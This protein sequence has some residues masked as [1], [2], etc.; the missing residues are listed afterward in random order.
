M[1]CRLHTLRTE[2]RNV[3]TA[4]KIESIINK[5]V[6]DSAAVPSFPR[7]EISN[8][9]ASC[10]ERGRGRDAGRAHLEV[11]GGGGPKL[12]NVVPAA[13][14]VDQPTDRQLGA[15]IAA[16]DV[17]LRV[18]VVRHEHLAVGPDVDDA[19]L[20][21]GIVRLTIIQPQRLV[22]AG[23]CWSLE[24]LGRKTTWPIPYDSK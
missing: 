18:V 20:A 16:A 23:H 2:T 3:I 21:V 24:N 10:P 15:A 6:C 9:L 11:V 12:C 13:R 14:R 22:R 5:P 1:S 17:L 7:R 4:D 8:S 19:G